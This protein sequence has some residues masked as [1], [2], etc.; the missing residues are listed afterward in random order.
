MQGDFT[1]MYLFAISQKHLH[2]LTGNLT[3]VEACYMCIQICNVRFHL[4]V[5]VHNGGFKFYTCQEA[6]LLTV[7]HNI[8]KET[9]VTNRMYTWIGSERATMCAVKRRYKGKFLQPMEMSNK[10]AQTKVHAGLLMYRVMQHD[11]LQYT[12][13]EYSITMG[14]GA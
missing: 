14:D 10:Y 5:A 2:L 13:I 7:Q 8:Q 3:Y 4:N 12:C 6:A 11:G 9:Y 1:N